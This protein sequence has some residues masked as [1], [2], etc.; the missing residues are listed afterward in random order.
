M[1]VLFGGMVVLFEG[2]GCVI[3]AYGVHYG[4]WSSLWGMVV[5]LGGIVFIMGYGLH[6]GVWLCY[7]GV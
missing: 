6:Y 2:Y 4:V 1:V 5:L 3:L 7:S